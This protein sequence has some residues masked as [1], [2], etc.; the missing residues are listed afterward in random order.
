MKKLLLV[1][2]TFC[3][4]AGQGIAKERYQVNG[5]LEIADTLFADQLRADD[6]TKVYIPKIRGD[7]IWISIFNKGMTTSTDSFLTTIRFVRSALS[8]S[9]TYLEGVITDSSESLLTKITAG[10]ST[11]RKAIRDT[12]NVLVANGTTDYKGDS[13]DFNSGRI[14]VLWTDT[15]HATYITGS[16]EIP[17]LDKVV[18]YS[19]CDLPDTAANQISGYPAL[20]FSDSGLGID[21]VWGIARYCLSFNGSSDILHCDYNADLV[22]STGD[23]SFGCLF[24]STSTD[25]T[26]MIWTTFNDPTGAYAYGWRVYVGADGYIYASLTGAAGSVTQNTNRQGYNDGKWHYVG[27]SRDSTAT[28]S[29]TLLIMVDDEAI[30]KSG[31]TGT[32][33]GGASV[34]YISIG[35]TS[36][37]HT[38]TFSGYLDCI[39]YF[40]G[41]ALTLNQH[42]VLRDKMATALIG[43]D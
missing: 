6:S 23:F 22:P 19:E 16:G 42:R 3:I 8:D 43:K 18:F 21:T 35:G 13:A 29:S 5:S 39:M 24:K 12:F 2:F 1:M 4:I 31:N 34:H 32:L 26:D 25:S 40:K 11:A 33:N 37:N 27:V 20:Q 14:D 10:D 36:A 30:A 17:P 41:A 9:V 15:L 38:S 28:T 7:T